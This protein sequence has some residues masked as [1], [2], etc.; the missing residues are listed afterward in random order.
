MP[1][2]MYEFQ[3]GKGS[4]VEWQQEYV[5]IYG[6]LASFRPEFKRGPYKRTSRRR[7]VYP[8]KWYPVVR[9]WDIY[10]TMRSR[11]GHG[12]FKGMTKKNFNWRFGGG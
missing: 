6:P 12:H 10:L 9:R 1:R 3:R 8:L 4:V 2:S 5:A 7:G 11:I